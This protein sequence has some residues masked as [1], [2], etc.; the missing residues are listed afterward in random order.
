[1]NAFVDYA[2][3]W[4]GVAVAACYVAAVVGGWQDWRRFNR[5]PMGEGE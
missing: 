2:E 5:N 1:M 3:W 4:I